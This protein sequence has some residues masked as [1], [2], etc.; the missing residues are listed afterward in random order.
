MSRPSLESAAPEWVVQ[1]QQSLGQLIWTPKLTTRLLLRPPFRFLHDIIT[2]V[3]RQTNWANDLYEPADT[4]PASMSTAH[5]KIR[6]LTMAADRVSASLGASVA[7]DAAEAVA[8]RGAHSTNEFLQLLALA[9]T[10]D[11]QGR[12]TRPVPAAVRPQPIQR[13]AVH[14]EPVS[15]EP[16]RD[17]GGSGAADPIAFGQTGLYGVGHEEE[18]QDEDDEDEDA[19]GGL[20]AYEGAPAGWRCEHARCRFINDD[21]DLPFCQMCARVRRPPPAASSASASTSHSSHSSHSSNRQTSVAAAAAAP[22]CGPSKSPESAGGSSASRDV[23]SEATGVNVGGSGVNAR[24]DATRDATRDRFFR[25]A[26]ADAVPVFEPTATGAWEAAASRSR[27]AYAS[28][29]NV[30]AATPATATA[31]A[32]RTPTAGARPTQVGATIRSMVS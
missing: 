18:G 1:T 10:T 11:S 17:D 14:D 5:G 13:Q 31:R 8:G 24:R 16:E 15:P 23:S 27:S 29:C 9:A 26:P 6:F 3:Q 19:D 2:E 7:F 30:P 4:S 21:M 32:G 20:Y 22:C 12:P 28:A 25:C